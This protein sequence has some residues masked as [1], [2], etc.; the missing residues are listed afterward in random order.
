MMAAGEGPKPFIAPGGIGLS[1]VVRMVAERLLAEPKPEVEGLVRL[2]RPW[3]EAWR[4]PVDL[5][6]SRIFQNDDRP[7]AV[8]FRIGLDERL[9]VHPLAVGTTGS[10]DASV[11]YLRI[12]DNRSWSHV[13]NELPDLPDQRVEV[14]DFD[15]ATIDGDPLVALIARLRKA[16]RSAP[17]EYRDKIKIDVNLEGWFDSTFKAYYERS[18]T[19]DDV[20][21][22]LARARA[23]REESLR[24]READE[25]A[26]LVRLKAKYEPLDG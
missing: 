22:E 20:I 26:E 24:R 18:A 4:G 16:V 19:L 13:L 14:I 23:E 15:L 25:R 6:A 11:N 17:V 2:I 3:L 12:S 5:S 7:P 10:L 8:E 21:A 9:E 1:T